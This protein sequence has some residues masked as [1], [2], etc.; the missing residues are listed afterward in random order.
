MRMM[1]EEEDLYLALNEM[2][3]VLEDALM[4]LV[5]TILMGGNEQVL[6]DD[7]QNLKCLSISAGHVLHLEIQMTLCLMMIV[8]LDEVMVQG[9]N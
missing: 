5:N 8:D 6:M 4:N 3:G 7:F 1:T 2:E 9:G